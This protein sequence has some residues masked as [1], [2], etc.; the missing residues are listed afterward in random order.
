MSPPD[1]NWADFLGA[2]LAQMLVDHSD[3]LDAALRG[4]MLQALGH[5][6]VAI[7]KRNVGPAYTNIAIMGAGVTAVA[8]E[9]L[10]EPS[11]LAYGRRRLQNV[12]KHTEYHSNFN[13][14]NSPTY[15]L[16]VL[17]ECDR[18]LQLVRDLE[19]RKA[20]EALRRVAWKTIA[21]SYHPGSRSRRGSS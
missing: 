11:F 19:T 3:K 12:V 14:Y 2:R 17:E 20:A 16:V 21:D 4:K 8:G 1:F 13:E 15:T 6:S 10:K 5:A 9:L 7:A 18:I